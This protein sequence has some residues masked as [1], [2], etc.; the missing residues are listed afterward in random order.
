MIFPLIPGNNEPHPDMCSFLSG[1]GEKVAGPNFKLLKLN[2][3]F[4][5]LID[6]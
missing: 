5:E 6:R 1:T 2:V 3:G 4:E